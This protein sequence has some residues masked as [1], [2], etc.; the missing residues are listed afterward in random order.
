MIIIKINIQNYYHNLNK[1]LVKNNND[2]KINTF[3][4]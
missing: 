4:S 1:Y 3:K 2:K